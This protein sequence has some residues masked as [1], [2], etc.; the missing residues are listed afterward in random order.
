[1]PTLLKRPSL[2]K[3]PA[4]PKQGV[5]R[6]GYVPL[7]D[8][9]PLLMAEALGLF[10]DNGLQV[11]LERELG[12]GSIR[13]KLVY[14]ELEAAHAP[15]GLLYSI[16]FG[17]HTRPCQVS[18]DLVLNLQGNAITL[19]R[20]L[21]E[22]GARDA[23]SFRQLLRSEAPRKPTLAVVSPFSSHNYLL[24]KW[25][26][27]ADIRPDRD[28]RIISLPPALVV[29]QMVSGQIDGF[30]VGEPWNSAAVLTDSGWIAATSATIA[31][32]HPEKV[33]IA[34]HELRQQR[35]EDYF[36]LRQALVTA[37]EF[38]DTPRGRQELVTLMQERALFPFRREVLENS[39][40]GPM[41]RGFDLPPETAPCLFFSRHDANRASVDRSVWI[42][43][44]LTQFA[45]TPVSSVQRQAF[46]DA[47]VDLPQMPKK[48]NKSKKKGN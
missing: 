2:K 38:C 47:F 33:L 26:T 41:Q 46:I 42:F 32:L 43:Q 7:V 5:I 11:K 22:K 35:S 48:P 15:G 6:I 23:H 18:T 39:L 8:A 40:I 29:E 9:A 21:W 12:W 20:R 4:R 3:S 25:L 45:A 24:R 30:C 28:V 17:T 16:L 19:S 37:A 36:G 34:T 13:E 1:M 27:A 31:P 14:G 10:N 44:S